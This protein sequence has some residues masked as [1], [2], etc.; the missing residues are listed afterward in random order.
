MQSFN[1]LYWENIPL[2]E[3]RNLFLL[4]PELY[5]VVNDT[6]SDAVWKTSGGLD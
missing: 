2:G 1:N 3:V 4:E 5:N 6:A